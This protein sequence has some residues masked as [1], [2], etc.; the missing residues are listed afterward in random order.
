DAWALKAGMP[1]WLV[2]FRRFRPALLSKF[3]PTKQ[4]SN[5]P[6]PRGWARVGRWSNAG[7]HDLEVWSGAVGEGAATEAFAFY[8]LQSKL[9]SLD[10]ILLNPDTAEVP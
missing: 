1:S 6:S 7:I 4:I 3:E 10:A 9:P 5:S 2:A 8:G